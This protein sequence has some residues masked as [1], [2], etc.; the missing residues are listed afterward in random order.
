MI[1][2][3]RQVSICCIGF[4]VIFALFNV[5]VNYNAAVH[6]KLAEENFKNSVENSLVNNHRSVQ[7]IPIPTLPDRESDYTQSI[8]K[9]RSM[10]VNKK[11]S[12]K[13]SHLEKNLSALPEWYVNSC[14]IKADNNM[15]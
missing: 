15:F 6:E 5:S 9:V 2:V 7:Q 8:S 13:N 1:P 10:R 4:I 12:V 3:L 11:N 14:K